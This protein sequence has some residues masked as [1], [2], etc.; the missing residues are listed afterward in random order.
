MT[1]RRFS[2]SAGRITKI[3]KRREYFRAAAIRETVQLADNDSPGR[4][5]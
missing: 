2:V 5:G 1:P 3:D 4:V